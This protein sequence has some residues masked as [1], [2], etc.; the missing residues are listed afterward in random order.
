[1]EGLYL[2]TGNDDL[3]PGVTQYKNVVAAW[4]VL[5]SKEADKII[6]RVEERRDLVFST[7]PSS[8]V[9]DTTTKRRIRHRDVLKIVANLNNKDLLRSLVY[10]RLGRKVESKDDGSEVVVDRGKSGIAIST[11]NYNTIIG[12]LANSKH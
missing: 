10:S 1:M 11:H 4:K 9:P 12:F 2:E 3:L 6:K 7:S 5:S 8:V